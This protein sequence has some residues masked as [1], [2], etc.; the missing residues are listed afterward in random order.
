ME[1]QKDTR[2]AGVKFPPPLIFAVC[3]L[4]GYGVEWMLPIPLT[5]FPALTYLGVAVICIGTFIIAITALSFYK[6]KTHIEPW[7]PTSRIITSGIFS[8]SR[9][10]IYLA[11]AIITLGIGIFLNSLWLILSCLPAMGLVFLVA[12]RK[13][14]HY[15]AEK[16][17]EEYLQYKAKVRRWL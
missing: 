3:M 13:E 17:G 15:L 2:G 12:V 7:K 8:F 6:A 10:P 4:V 5:T 9:N 16:F 14:E 11:F 1:Q